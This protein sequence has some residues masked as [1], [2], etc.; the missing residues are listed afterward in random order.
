MSQHGPGVQYLLGRGDSPATIGC[1]HG[2]CDDVSD[3]GG[4]PDA[5][6]Q[7]RID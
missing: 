4:E 1:D 3:R 6:A 5:S 2:P 7:S